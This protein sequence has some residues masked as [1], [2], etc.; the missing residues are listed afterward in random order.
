MTTTSYIDSTVAAATASAVDAVLAVSGLAAIPTSAYSALG[1]P[2][3]QSRRPARR[4]AYIDV[5]GRRRGLLGRCRYSGD[6]QTAL[7]ADRHEPGASRPSSASGLP[8]GGSGNPSAFTYTIPNLTPG[9]SYNV[10]LD[11]AEIY[12]GSAGQRQT[13][14]TSREYR[15]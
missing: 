4:N 10:Q 7:P 3:W 2:L 1:E 5:G 15:C 6:L 12:Y 11:F 14:E 9:A 13:E 8:D